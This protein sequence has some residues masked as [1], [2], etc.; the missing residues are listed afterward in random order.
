MAIGPDRVQVLKYEEGSKGGNAADDSMGIPAEI[1]P[2]EDVLETA[3]LYV[4]DALNRDENVYIDRDGDDLRFRDVNNP[5]PVTLT[6]LAT[7]GAGLTPTTHR[8]LDQLVHEISEDS[9]EELTYGAG[10]RVDNITVWTDVGKTIK[11]REEQYTYTGNN[12]TT[13]VTIQYNAA[14]VVIVG[15]TMTET[16]TYSGNTLASLTRVMT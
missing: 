13:I 6:D 7:G 14:G 12:A 10:N 8:A 5:V 16:L 11:I 3:G 1:Q 15:E 9:F 4:Q 2:Q